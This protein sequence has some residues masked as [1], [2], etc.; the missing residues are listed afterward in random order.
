MNVKELRR[1]I[2]GLP[3]DMPVRVFD[4]DVMVFC[5]LE[6]VKVGLTRASR[7]AGSYTDHETQGQPTLLIC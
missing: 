3:D 1:V 7:L 6:E 4:W 2:S 5:D